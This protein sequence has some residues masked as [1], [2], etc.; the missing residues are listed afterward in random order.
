M[1]V[2]LKYQKLWYFIPVG[3]MN[4]KILLKF[5]YVYFDI[6]ARLL[7]FFNF[8]YSLMKNHSLC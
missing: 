5:N 7:L 2:W 3:K 4:L 6:D 8:C 1:E